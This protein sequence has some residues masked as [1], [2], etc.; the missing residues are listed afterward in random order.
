MGKASFWVILEKMGT[1]C[2][3]EKQYFKVLCY[4]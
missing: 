1:G 4:G 3:N 2:L